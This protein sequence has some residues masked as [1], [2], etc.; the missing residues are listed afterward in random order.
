M[1][2]ITYIY[3]S[4]FFGWLNPA[5]CVQQL[6]IQTTSSDRNFWPWRGSR[7]LKSWGPARHSKKPYSA[8]FLGL[9]GLSSWTSNKTNVAFISSWAQRHQCER[10]GRK[11]WINDTMRVYRLSHWNGDVWLFQNLWKDIEKSMTSS[12]V[13][14]YYKINKKKHLKLPLSA[15]FYWGIFGGQYKFRTCDPCSVKTPLDHYFPQWIHWVSCSLVTQSSIEVVWF[16]N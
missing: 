6:P 8:F 14:L 13:G 10:R 7:S 3:F 15:W 11:Q 2:S 4:L 16:W 9:V 12:K 1:K 5:V